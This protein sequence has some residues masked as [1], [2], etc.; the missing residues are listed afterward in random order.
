MSPWKQ[1][2][3]ASIGLGLRWPARRYVTVRGEG[4]ESSSTIAI[5]QRA[6]KR[7][8]QFEST[9]RKLIRVARRLFATRGYGGTSIEDITRRA[10]VTRGAL[11][12]HFSG[13]EE[14]FRAVFEQVEQELVE[15]AALATAAERRPERRLEAGAN[16]FLDACLDRDV[17][18]IVLLDAPSVL[19]WET[20]QEIDAQYALAG[21]T[22]A[23]QA[24]MDDGYLAKQPAEPLAHVLLGAL[25]QA[26][27]VI[28][29]SD[30]VAATRTELGRTIKRLLDGLKRP[31]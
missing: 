16:A 9:R 26:A 29:R 17:Q 6:T 25:N 4:T 24:A 14:I 23:L 8:A 18:Q 13:K 10:R 11:Y 21:L 5:V 19:G 7:Q 12:H 28:A 31:S 22:A 20:W 30:D 2:A 1:G 27:L 3:P 15:K